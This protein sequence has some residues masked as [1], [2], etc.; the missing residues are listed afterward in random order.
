MKQTIMKFAL[1]IAVVATLGAQSC[2][3]IKND[4]AKNAATPFDYTAS[5]DIS[6]PAS[7]DTT[8]AATLGTKTISTNFDSII[9]AASGGF[10]SFSSISSI[11]IT[12]VV[13]TITSGSDV[14]NNFANF[15]YIGAVFNRHDNTTT[16]YTIADASTNTDVYS[17]NLNLPIVDATK[18]VK[19]YLDGSGATLD[20]LVV[21][22]LRRKTTANLN[23]H[24]DLTYH[25]SF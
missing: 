19:Q 6:V 10:A 16:A 11:K 14:N 18:D 2:D 21:G 9:S 4:I 7:S 25:V 1:A 8:A 5:V 20:Y 22:K 17:I 13:F 24:V 23:V 12:S 15:E 3:K